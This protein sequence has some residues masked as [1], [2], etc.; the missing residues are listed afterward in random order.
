MAC[1]GASYSNGKD[2]GT[3]NTA[4]TATRAAARSAAKATDFALRLNGG[5]LSAHKQQKHVRALTVI[6]E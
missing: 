4:S 1:Y 6:N 3:M 2:Y 5:S